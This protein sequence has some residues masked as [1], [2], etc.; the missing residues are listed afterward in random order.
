MPTNY[1]RLQPP[2]DYIPRITAQYSGLGYGEYQWLES[3]NAPAWTPLNKPLSDSKVGLI[4]TGGIY[5][6]G[7]TA[8]HFKDDT[9][10]RAI[11]TDVDVEDLRATHF[12]YDLTDARKDINVV[13]P[14]EQLRTMVDEGVIDSI[15][16]D[17]YTLMGGIYSTRRVREE[18]I[19]ALVDRVLADEVDVVL[20]VPV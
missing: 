15:A 19:P 12:A 13:F 18:L 4:C 5:A 7:Q 3:Q 17:A 1:Q 10:Y 2:V 6:A 20:L 8:F 11:S 16:P 14:V 9:T